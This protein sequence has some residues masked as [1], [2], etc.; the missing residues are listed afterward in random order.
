MNRYTP[1][2]RLLLK[3]DKEFKA[4]EYS[5]ACNSP[6][7]LKISKRNYFSSAKIFIYTDM[8]TRPSL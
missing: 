8:S 4:H 3:T 5:H 7:F 6:H 1:P 2:S